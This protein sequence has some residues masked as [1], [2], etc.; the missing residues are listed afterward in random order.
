MRVLV[1]GKGGREAALVWKLSKSDRVTELF[2]APGNPGTSRFAENVGID[3]F[4]IDGLLGFAIEREIDLVVVG[5]EKPLSMGIVDIFREKGV[6]IF[7]PN[8]A[9]A[10]LETSKVFAKNFMKRHKIPTANYRVERYYLQALADLEDFDFPLVIKAD[11]LAAGKG[12]FI[13]DNVEETRLLLGELLL[14]H[15]LGEAG[16]RI[17]LEEFLIGSELSLFVLAD[18]KDYVE[19]GEARD[20]KKALDGNFGQNTG[21]MGA[22]SPVPDYSEEIREEFRERIL[23]PTMEGLISDGLKYTGLLYF[24]LILTANGLRVLEFNCRFG[25]PET[26]AILPRIEFDLAKVLY[27]CATGSLGIDKLHLSE[28]TSVAVVAA[29]QGYPG[30]FDTCHAISGLDTVD[31]NLVFQAGTTFRDSRIV[32]SGGRVLTVTALDKSP[33]IAREKAYSTLSRIFYKGITY[34]TDI[35]AEFDVNLNLAEREV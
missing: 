10:R 4:D 22:I 2:C 31:D 13:L 8:A 35:G 6:T 24:G 12:V 7:G 1:V 23:E 17:V 18:G 16:S 25:D 11:G 19:L 5:P 26:Q 32:T 29:S 21:G 3:D 33:K 9:C 30:E 14:N 15:S 28:E 20:F 27:Q 34:R